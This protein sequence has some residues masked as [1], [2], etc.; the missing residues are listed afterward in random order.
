[1][2]LMYT[3]KTKY[4]FTLIELMIVIAILAILALIMLPNMMR[5][6]DA[7][8]LSSCK[9]N[10]RGIA[11]AME[12]YATD[13]SGM[14]PHDINKLVEKNSKGDAYLRS[15]PKCPVAGSSDPYLSGYE[16]ISAPKNAYTL[17]CQGN[18]HKIMGLDDNYPKYSAV[19]GLIE[20][21]NAM[22]DDK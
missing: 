18:Y 6:R 1:M 10:L 5:S 11:A 16:V 12:S 19:V 3:R 13:N 14:Y 17:C 9:Y 8:K 21:Q 15:I 20:S 2:N 22:E 4:G 7:A